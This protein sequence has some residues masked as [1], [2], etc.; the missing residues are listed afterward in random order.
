[1]GWAQAQGLAMPIKAGLT[2]DV[3][4]VPAF[5]AALQIVEFVRGLEVERD[6][7]LCSGDSSAATTPGPES[8]RAWR[9]LRSSTG[10][11]DEVLSQGWTRP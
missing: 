8:T 4:R 2:I 7:E 6:V 11:I 1:M 5:E 3:T 10:S 9:P